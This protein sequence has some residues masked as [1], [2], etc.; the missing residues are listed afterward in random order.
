M[1]QRVALFRW[2]NFHRS[3]L[4]IKNFPKLVDRLNFRSVN[5]EHWQLLPNNFRIKFISE[6]MTPEALYYVDE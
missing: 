5:Y 2:N 1:L 3:T 6:R 4:L